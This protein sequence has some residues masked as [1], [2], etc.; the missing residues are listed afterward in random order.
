MACIGM[1]TGGAVTACDA[2]RKRRTRGR[3]GTAGGVRAGGRVRQGRTWAADEQCGGG[4]ALGAGPLVRGR[5][6]GWGCPCWVGLEVLLGTIVPQSHFARPVATIH[7]SNN[8]RIPAR[9][10]GEQRSHAPFLLTISPP[11]SSITSYYVTSVLHPYLSSPILHN[12]LLCDICPTPP[13]TLIDSASATCWNPH[14]FGERHLVGL[15]A[16]VVQ[17]G[18]LFRCVRLSI[19]EPGAA[20]C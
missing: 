13:P 8:Y 1:A 9:K 7:A 19:C 4:R 3:R 5:L 15:R 17:I 18:I 10:I 11:P 20:T 16:S 12:Q 14:L 2:G 6:E